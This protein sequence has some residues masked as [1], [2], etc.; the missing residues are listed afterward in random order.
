V[1]VLYGA[2]YGVD[3]FT[4]LPDSKD[5]GGFELY[6]RRDRETLPQPML[7][8]LGGA[9]VSMIH[10]DTSDLNTQ[11]AGVLK[12]VGVRA[13]VTDRPLFGEFM[14]FSLNFIKQNVT[15]HEPGPDPD[16]REWLE[17]THY[18]R[19]RKEELAA[20]DDADPRF[21]DWAIGMFGKPELYPDY[22]HWRGIN[23]RSDKAKTYFGPWT[24]KLE[25]FVYALCDPDGRRYF[26]K[27]TPVAD[28]PREILSMERGGW[29]YY[30]SD[31]TSW[32]CH[33]DDDRY[34]VETA[35]FAWFFQFL[36]GIDAFMKNFCEAQ[37]SI[38]TCRTQLLTFRALLRRMS[39]EMSTSVG[40][41]F[42]NLM[43]WLFIAYTSR[44]EI[45]IRVEGD[46]AIMATSGPIDESL[47]RR[48]G[49]K[50]KLE[51]HS[52]ITR[53]SFCGLVFDREDLANVTDPLAELA[54]AQWGPGRLAGTRRTRLREY[55]RCK[56]LSMAHCYPGCP[57]VQEY[58]HFLLRMTRGSDI[59]WMLNRRYMNQWEMDRLHD[60][61]DFI[62]HGKGKDATERLIRPVG[63]Q[64][65]HLVEEL[66]GLS[67]HTQL[68]VERELREC[69]SLED[70][71]LRILDD[72]W[73]VNWLKYT[74][75]AVRRPVR[76]VAIV[77]WKI[78]KGRVN[79]PG[80][81]P[82]QMSD[83]CARAQARARFCVLK[84]DLFG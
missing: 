24:K 2:R 26:I 58:A 1:G 42:M 48:L 47:I 5:L 63:M 56:A 69:N 82:L 18:S 81:V 71:R 75:E 15:P 55:L 31:F 35:L 65:R 77:P 11:V 73:P 37:C 9:R 10:V 72:H 8:N 51:R 53:A 62:G 21:A 40:N 84:Q 41:G 33:F 27:N 22:K 34:Q 30:S 19:A 70:L 79:M 68:V 12:R 54:S 6:V 17:C 29:Y 74:E 39:G 23:A 16:R 60:A 80:V 7:T 45:R 38:N 25:K 44:V 76:E 20:I 46:D 36:E 4:P 83:E 57:I 52:D 43:T 50:C 28:R 78:E 32:E 64:T 59:K 14:T 61:L 49:L 3:F 66:Y 13:P 67:V